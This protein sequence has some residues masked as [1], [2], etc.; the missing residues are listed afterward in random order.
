MPNNATLSKDQLAIY[1]AGVFDA[2]GAIS[3]TRPIASAAQHTKKHEMLQRLNKAFKGTLEETPGQ[4]KGEGKVFVQ[5]HLPDKK[6]RVAFFET[7]R[8]YSIASETIDRHLASLA[9]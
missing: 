6:Q 5:W 4:G 1:A 7:I 8:Q 3:I 9:K 2:S